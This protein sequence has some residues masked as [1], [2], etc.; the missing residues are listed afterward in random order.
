MFMGIELDLE[1]HLQLKSLIGVRDCKFM[2]ENSD[3]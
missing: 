2:L 3:T 1:K